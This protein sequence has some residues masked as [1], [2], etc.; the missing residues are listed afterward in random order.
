MKEQSWLNY[1]FD[2]DDYYYIVFL[3]LLAN[4]IHVN[5][6]VHVLNEKLY[7]STKFVVKYILNQNL[8]L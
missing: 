1:R 2:D 3:I 4:L 5:L 7:S 6:N 8:Y